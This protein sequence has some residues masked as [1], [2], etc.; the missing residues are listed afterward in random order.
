MWTDRV[1]LRKTTL[2]LSGSRPRLRVI[3]VAFGLLLIGLL[4]LASA[5]RAQVFEII[6]PDVEQGGFEIEALSGVVLS[7][8]A[9]D[10]DRAGHEFSLGYAPFSFWFSEAVIAIAKP[11]G[12][13][14]EYDALEWENTFVIPLGTAEEGVSEGEEDLFAVEGL[15]AY[16]AWEIPKEGGASES[17]LTVGP[18]AAVRLGPVDAVVN[19]FAEIPFSEDED[20]GLAF[21][22]SLSTPVADFGRG[23]VA[24]GVE[25]HG[26][27]DG[28][29]VDAQPLDEQGHFV[30]PAVYSQLDLFKDYTLESRLAILFGLT[31]ESSDAVASLNI[32]LAF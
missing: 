30:G 13:G 15:G 31:E 25:G 8:V 5:A 20:A 1:R 6:E 28:A 26:A 29:F 24:L 27:I 18:I 17:S 10:Q 11:V 4:T 2:V 12:E 9:G 21:A 7:D 32:S 23:N 22:V 19:L 14:V 3:A 16:L